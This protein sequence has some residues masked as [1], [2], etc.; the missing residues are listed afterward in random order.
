MGLR[1]KGE[2]LSSGG[3]PVCVSDFIPVNDI[4]PRFDEITSAWTKLL[5]VRMLPHIDSE[6]GFSLTLHDWIDLIEALGHGKCSVFSDH[7]PS[8]ATPELGQGCLGELLFE[9]IE[10]AEVPFDC[11]GDVAGWLTSTVR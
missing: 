7:K 10:R 6:D 11:R 3:H 9:R 1:L 2:E 4:P 5:V 8:P